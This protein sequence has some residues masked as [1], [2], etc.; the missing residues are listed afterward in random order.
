[1]SEDFR[2][3]TPRRDDDGGRQV[4]LVTV[5]AGVGALLLVAS[6]VVD[7]AWADEPVTP[8]LPDLPS[9]PTLPSNLPT[10]LPS[11][12]SDYPTE[13]PTELPTDLPTDLPDLPDLPSDFPTELPEIPDLPTELP[14]LPELPGGD[15]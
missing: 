14:T 13:F 2:D 10:E 5:A 12:P 8:D 7:V 15:G 11:L 3:E 1:M 4:R 6:V 9:R